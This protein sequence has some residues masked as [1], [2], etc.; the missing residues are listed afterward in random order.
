[1]YKYAAYDTLIFDLGNTLLPIA[2]N[3]TTQAF[4]SLGFVGD[5]GE[6]TKEIQ[7]VFAKYQRG[8][9][10]TTTF[11]DC[12]QMRLPKK[13]TKA[14]ITDAWNAMLLEFPQVHFQLLKKLHTTHTTLLLSNTNE[15]HA[16]CFEEKARRQGAPLSSYFDKVYYSHEIGMSK[17][18]EEIYNYLHNTSY[19]L[20]KKVLFLDDLAE[21]LRIPR[22]LGWEAV[23][24]S[25]DKTILDFC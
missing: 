1:M 13:V 18:E 12:L 3:L 22:R 15:L 7:T 9:L 23:Q 5:I 10:S 17:P 6:P 16:Q 24:I 19:C 20:G 21:N 14:Q 11:L 8:L 4:R 2:P 25:P